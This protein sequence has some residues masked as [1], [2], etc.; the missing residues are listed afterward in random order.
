MHRLT[1]SLDWKIGDQLPRGVDRL[2]TSQKEWRQRKLNWI[3][4][5]VNKHSNGKSPSWIGNTSSNGGFS[6]AMLDYRRVINNE[7]WWIQSSD[8]F[9][10]CRFMRVKSCNIGNQWIIMQHAINSLLSNFSAK[11]DDWP[12]V[13]QAIHYFVFF[14][15]FG[16][17]IWVG[18]SSR[19]E[20]QSSAPK[21]P[22]TLPT[23]SSLHHGVGKG[24]RLLASSSP[25]SW[26]CKGSDRSCCYWWCSLG[27]CCCCYSCH[28]PTT[29]TTQKGSGSSACYSN[30]ICCNGSSCGCWEGQG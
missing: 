5:L 6:I 27:W 30:S 2:N 14:E 7:F 25:W 20:T 24:K 28:S 17:I 18:G 10:H 3:Y 22:G 26:N 12:G 9:I 16:A 23:P 15:L 1:R 8:P 21:F 11:I 19:E 13:N 29:T 4:P